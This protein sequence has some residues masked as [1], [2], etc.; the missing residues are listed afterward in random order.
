MFTLVPSAEV[1]SN[2]CSINPS[3]LN[4]AGNDFN[5]LTCSNPIGPRKASPIW[6]LVGHK[7]VSEVNQYSSLLWESTADIEDPRIQAAKYN[8]I[9]YVILII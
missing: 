8:Y 2:C 5:T 7:K 1:A 9:F 4:C 6:S 3:A